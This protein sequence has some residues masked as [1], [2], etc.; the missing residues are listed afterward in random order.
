MRHA[1]QLKKLAE[2]LGKIPPQKF[3]MSS[4]GSGVLRPDDEG[5]ECNFAGCAIGWM[6]K[7][8]P[9]NTLVQTDKFGRVKFT[10]PILGLEGRYKVIA[11]YFDISISEAKYLFDPY[12]YPTN[13]DTEASEVE[14]RILEVLKNQGYN[15]DS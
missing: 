6:P 10:R 5:F 7:L 2:G 8:V 15:S 14:A 11:H 4:W 9:E 12:T 13:V 3:N 1:D